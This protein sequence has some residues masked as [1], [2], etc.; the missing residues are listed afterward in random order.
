MGV[1]VSK[2]IGFAY[3]QFLIDNKTL[4]LKT[5]TQIPDELWIKIILLLNVQDIAKLMSVCFRFQNLC[6][7]SYVWKSVVL[8]RLNFS[9]KMQ[10][11]LRSNVLKGEF[12]KYYVQSKR[13]Q[14]DW[15]SIY[16]NEKDQLYKRYRLYGCG[17]RKATIIDLRRNG[18]CYISGSLFEIKG[19]TNV[20]P[21]EYAVDHNGMRPFYHNIGP[22]K[23]ISYIYD[24][25]ILYN[26]RG[27]IYQWL[28]KESH[29]QSLYTVE[30][31]CPKLIHRSQRPIIYF[32]CTPF[33]NYF[34]DKDYRVYMWL[35]KTVAS[36]QNNS[37]Y[38]QMVEIKSLK[39]AKIYKIKYDQ[40]SQ[41]TIFC[42][43]NGNKLIEVKDLLFY[44][45]NNISKS[46]KTN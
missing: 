14:I 9:K 19:Q 16:K 46:Q 8:N 38:N 5:I 15:I 35:T 29:A 37:C 42:Y 18:K 21:P 20:D 2:I 45:I 4:E 40:Q 22:V 41:M 36:V 25:A 27:E 12:E 31:N 39:N 3:N 43:S 11:E 23:K 24:I 34:I 13:F 7:S 6:K 32:K 26:T 33:M 10:E 1:I 30:N 17:K 28:W 44:L